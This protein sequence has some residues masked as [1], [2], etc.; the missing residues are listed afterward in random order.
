[1]WDI[2][3]ELRK[4]ITLNAYIKKEEKSQISNISCHLKDLEKE[5]QNQ[6]E[7]RK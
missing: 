3:K 7:G 5:E 1:L 2:A 6:T 4:F